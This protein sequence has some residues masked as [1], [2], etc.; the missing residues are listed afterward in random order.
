[1][2]KLPSKFLQQH[3]SKIRDGLTVLKLV[4][5]DP[6]PNPNPNSNPNPKPNLDPKPNWLT[7]SP[8][9]L[10]NPNPHQVAGLGRCAGLPLDL[11]GMP[12]EV[13]AMAHQACKERA[14]RPLIRVRVRVG[15]GVIGLGLG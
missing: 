9:L 15:I 3:G 11:G 1:M 5:P 10:P 7:L 12:T 8:Y 2:L 4:S 6:R 14:T 13:V